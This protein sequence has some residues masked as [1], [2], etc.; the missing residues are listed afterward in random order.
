MGLLAAVS[1]FAPPT[2]AF[3]ANERSQYTSRVWEV[4]DGLPHNSIQALV[5]THDGY[6][7][8]GTQNGLARFDGVRCTVFDSKNV[9]QM[10]NPF[11]SAL[12][13]TPDGSLWIGTVNAGL[14]RRSGQDFKLYTSQDGLVDDSIRAL[15][16]GQDG[17]VWI[18]TT[19]GISRFKNEH[20]ETITASNELASTVVRGFCHDREWNL[21]IATDNGLNQWRNGQISAYPIERTEPD[22]PRRLSRAVYKD[23]AENLWVGSSTGLSCLQSDGQLLHYDRFQEGLPDSFVT[24]LCEGAGGTLWVGTYDGLG[25]LMGNRFTTEITSAGEAYGQVNA[26]LTD[27]EGNVWV[28][29]KDGLWQLRPKPF[30]TY[31]KQHGLPNNNVTS[32]RETSDGSIW[33][34]TWGGGFVRWERGANIMA[35]Y[36]A[37]HAGHRS[38]GVAFDQALAIGEGN[39]GALWFGT[40][41]TSGLFRWKTNTLQRFASAEGLTDPAIRAIHEDRQGNVWLGTRTALVLFKHGVFTR[42]TT[43]EGLAGPTVRS[44]CEDHEGS[45]WIGTS[46]GLSRR[47]EGRFS[48]LTTRDGLPHNT[49]IALHEDA[50]KTL[51]IGTS[52]GLCRIKLTDFKSEIPNAGIHSYTTK[53]GLFSDEIFEILEDDSGYLWMS[54][55][56]GIFRIRKKDVTEMDSGKMPG[57]VCTVYG[58][59]EGLTTIQCNGVAKPAG[60]KAKDGRLWFA[61]TKG[62]T[63]VD[64]GTVAKE[65]SIPPPVAIEEVIADKRRLETLSGFLNFEI[66]TLNLSP[67]RGELEF[68]YTALSFAAPEKNRFKYQLEGIDRDWVDAGT[69]RSAYYNNVQPGDYTFR[70][71]ACNNDGL[72]NTTGSSLKISLQPHFWQTKWFLALSALIAIASVS[73]A[74]RYIT[75]KNV[76]RQFQRLEQR[77]AVERERSRIAQDMHDDLGARLSE[78]LILS[79]MPLSHGT[80]PA[81]Y[82]SKLKRIAA[83]SRDLV[84]NLDAIVWAVNPKHDSLESFVTYL[85]EYVL[86]YFESSP[87][88]CLFELPESVPEITMP[89]EARHNL[90]L[91]VKEALHNVVKHSAA[92]EVHLQ[93]RAEGNNLVLVLQDNGKGFS[94]SGQFPFGNGL[95]NM[96][97]RMIK[98]GG[99]FCLHSEPGKGTRLELF[100]SLKTTL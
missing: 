69:R 76:Q 100:L 63:V 30:Q 70:V 7:W 55:P 10:R 37:V 88:R 44:L 74:A 27:R 58:K 14:I 75:W 3:S 79:N 81:S 35:S 41:F 65:N 47:K 66:P 54:S 31:T 80:D 51:W 2:F 93:L 1:L 96:N 16:A 48:S 39:A 15:F 38:Y 11:I 82:A 72:W 26:L 62:V 6:L 68:H 22:R 20:F 57:L 19:N 99:R 8:I 28:A 4:D 86:T 90:L 67:G 64:P 89:S 97:E 71:I 77:H 23:N 12:C 17:S 43:N 56:K 46:G 53:D 24:S 40:D 49:V 45:L 25:R 92:S 91:V 60:W 78:I 18:G 83:G 95:N 32:V 61:T 50:E 85:Q 59:A 87:I 94:G 73:S 5:Q 36:D 34:G 21:V 42:F 9:P 52:G 13:E 98:I 84:D 29:T 33:F